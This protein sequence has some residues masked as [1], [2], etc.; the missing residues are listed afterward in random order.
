MLSAYRA[1]LSQI[2]RRPARFMTYRNGSIVGAE[3]KSNS[4]YSLVRVENVNV[5]SWG[6]AGVAV[7]IGLI[8]GVIVGR[9]G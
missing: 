4:K 7:G 1:G 3:A 8:V 6:V 2:S 9:R 5:P